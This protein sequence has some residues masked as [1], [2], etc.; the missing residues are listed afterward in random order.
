MSFVN[1]RE[2]IRIANL[3]SR[4]KIFEVKVYTKDGESVPDSL[5]SYIPVDGCFEDSH[6]DD[7]V[8]VC[9]GTDVHKTCDKA[10]LNWLRRNARLGCSIVGLY[11]GAYAMAKAGL[12]DQQRA[13]IHWEYRSSF[14]ENFP[15]ID[16]V[17]YTFTCGNRRYST[18][19]GTASIDLMLH[20]IS[21]LAGSDIANKVS[22]N[23]NYT[24]IRLL[25]HSAKV[26]TVDRL[27]FRHPK[28]SQIVALM[29]TNLEEPLRPSDL[30]QTVNISTR[31]LERLFRR[32]LKATPKR[33]YTDLRLQHARL[34]LLQTNYSV[35]D[36]ALSCGFN[37]ASL[38]SR[39]FR[40]RF[41]TTPFSLRG[42]E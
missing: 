13:T 36:V 30:A 28:I 32:Y 27:G 24:N 4:G 1:A 23:L 22:A 9:S 39:R 18:A 16:L 42:E 7:I 29:E 3:L 21:K 41:G 19:G 8:I 33:Y 25:Q 10:I 15:N 31:Q 26:Q 38:F 5:G 37:S 11:T 14:K 2:T 17:D 20:L 40:E 35:L 12:L 34:L 6:R